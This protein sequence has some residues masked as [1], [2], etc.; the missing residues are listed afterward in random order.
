[1]TKYITIFIITSVIMTIRIFSFEATVI[2]H[3]SR[4]TLDGLNAP[5]HRQSYAIL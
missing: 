3:S 4:I 5:P 2:V 1:M